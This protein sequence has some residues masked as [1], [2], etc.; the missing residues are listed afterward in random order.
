MIS[1]NSSQHLLD[2]QLLFS[3]PIYINYLEPFVSIESG[4]SD[5]SS[6]ATSRSNAE[7][8]VGGHLKKSNFGVALGHQNETV[9]RSRSFI[10]SFGYTYMLSQNPLHVFWGGE[11]DDANYAASV[12]Y[13]SFH[14]KVTDQKEDAA[15]LTLEIELGAWQL[16]ASN[17]LNNKVQSPA[18]EFNGSGTIGVGANYIGDNIEAYAS[19]IREPVKSLVSG[20]EAEF[21]ILQLL[22]LGIVDSNAKEMNDIFW[23]AEINTV[24]VDCRVKGGINCDQ[25]FVSTTL[26]VWIGIEAQALPWLKM[27]SSV[28][29]TAFVNQSRDDVGYPAGSFTNATGAV[30][31]YLNGPNTTAVSAGLGIVMNRVTVDGTLT[32]ATSQQLNAVNFLDQ[33]SLKYNF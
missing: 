6:A 13:S 22:K 23:G 4:N 17:V 21:H 32:A 12:F 14:D 31:E 30:S 19:F 25:S 9:L 10:N 24:R 29:Q 18:N 15:G 16:T 7:A 5:A 8:I 1:L 2:E 11:T 28:R 26:P 20:V 27:R 3:N 33:L